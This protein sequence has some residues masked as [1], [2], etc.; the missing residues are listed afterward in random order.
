MPPNLGYISQLQRLEY[1][2]RK[3][4]HMSLKSALALAKALG[5]E[6]EEL[7]LLSY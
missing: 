7:I 2:K 5:V 1:G 3:I 6:V 4:E